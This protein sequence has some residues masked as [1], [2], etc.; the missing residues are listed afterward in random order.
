MVADSSIKCL[1]LDIRL[2]GISGLELQQRLINRYNHTIPTI[3]ISGHGNKEVISTVLNKG[4]IGFVSKPF[5]SQ[6]LT[7]YIK[8]AFEKFT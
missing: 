1:L 8:K 4:A 5:D 3:F 6:L 7:S 2:T